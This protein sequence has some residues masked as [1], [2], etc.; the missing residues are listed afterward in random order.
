MWSKLYF[1]KHAGRSLPQILFSDPDYFFWSIEKNIFNGRLAMEADKLTRMVRHIRIPKPEPENW[2]VEYVFTPENK[3]SRFQI[4]PRNRGQ[5]MGSSITSRTR[6]I[7]MSVIRQAC[8][9]DKSGYKQFLK[10]LKYHLFGNSSTRMTATRCEEFFD[11]DDNFC[12]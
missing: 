9:Y 2:C 3:F 4:I 7:D 5:H 1:G 12:S 11:D 10:T 6:Y 8:Q